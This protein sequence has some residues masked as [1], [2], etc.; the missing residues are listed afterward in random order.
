[1]AAHKVLNEKCFVCFIFSS[2]WFKLH[3]QL[4]LS[5]YRRPRKTFSSVQQSATLEP[6]VVYCGVLT[7]NPL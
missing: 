6:L 3:S 1:M 5:T 4:H 2:N 7:L